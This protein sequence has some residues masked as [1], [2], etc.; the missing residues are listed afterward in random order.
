MSKIGKVKKEEWSE[1]GMSGRI[2][3]RMASISPSLT[4]A[5]SAKA[6]A[7]NPKNPNPIRV[8][9]TNVNFHRMK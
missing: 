5:I 2:A 4:L 1:R 6:K 9:P 8:N 7:M 3:K